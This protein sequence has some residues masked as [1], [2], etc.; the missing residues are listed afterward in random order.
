[1]TI[2]QGCSNYS[3]QGRNWL[4]E[5]YLYDCIGLFLYDIYHI[6]ANKDVQKMAIKMM[7]VCL[8]LP[9]SSSSSSLSSWLLLSLLFSEY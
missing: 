3:D 5:I 2:P 8:R 6:T 1:L 7:A 9:S 4:I